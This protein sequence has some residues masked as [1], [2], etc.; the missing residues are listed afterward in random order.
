M[1]EEYNFKSICNLT[2]KVMGLPD[3]ALASKSRKRPL[4][5]ARSIIKS[6]KHIWMLLAQ[7]RFLLIMI[8]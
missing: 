2:T 6:I 8:L 5:V 1:I 3:G 4:Q 7:K